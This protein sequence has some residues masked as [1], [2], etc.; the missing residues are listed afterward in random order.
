MPKRWNPVVD[1]KLK[2]EMCPGGPGH[3]KGPHFKSQCVF[4]RQVA[5]LEAPPIPDIP[6]VV[7]PA[8]KAPAKKSSSKKKTLV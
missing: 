7:E 2:T 5:H 8:P 1:A 6:A 3:A 4:C